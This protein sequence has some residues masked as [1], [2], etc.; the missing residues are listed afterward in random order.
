MARLLVVGHPMCW[1]VRVLLGLSSGISG[2]PL[3]EK[4]TAIW[5]TGIWST[6]IWS[7]GKFDQPNTASLRY[8]G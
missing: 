5:S 3:S 6:A 7:T 1:R 8:D 2:N 4:S